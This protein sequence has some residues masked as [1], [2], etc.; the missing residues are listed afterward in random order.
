MITAFYRASNVY[1][2]ALFESD[3]LCHLRWGY[4]YSSPD[5][6]AMARPVAKDSSR[7]SILNYAIQHNKPDCWHVALVVGNLSNLLNLLPFPLPWM[8]FERRN[9]DLKFYDFESLLS[10]INTRDHGTKSRHIQTGEASAGSNADSA[11]AARRNHGHDGR[12]DGEHAGNPDAGT[13]TP[14]C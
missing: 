1:D 12:A 11:A 9:K 8:S 5:L 7:E 6:F 4:V 3:L 14:S 2:S 13:S 10:K